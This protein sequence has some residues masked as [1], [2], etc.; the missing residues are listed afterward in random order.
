MTD[1]KYI[2]YKT[3]YINLKNQLG[4]VKYTGN[5]ETTDNVNYTWTEQNKDPIEYKYIPEDRNKILIVVDCGIKDF[6]SNL[7]GTAP[8][9]DTR[10]KPNN[11]YHNRGITIISV[12]EINDLNFDSYQ[13][14]SSN[15][16]YMDNIKMDNL[17]KIV[18][19]HK[20]NETALENPIFLNIPK[21][22]ITDDKNDRISEKINYIINLYNYVNSN[23]LVNKTKI[24]HFSKFHT[25]KKGVYKINKKIYIYN[26]NNLVSCIGDYAL[27]RY[28]IGIYRIYINKD[29]E[30]NILIFN[31]TEKLSIEYI[32]D[33][34]METSTL[35]NMQFVDY[36]ELEVIKPYVY[37]KRG[38]DTIY[39]HYFVYH[40]G[41]ICAVENIT[42][43]IFKLSDLCITAENLEPTDC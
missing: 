25:I 4:G 31:T 41:E 38:G 2:K 24:N 13:H 11:Y 43:F 36:P 10:Q 27:Y 8:Q 5:M 26:D 19:V 30:K 12:N 33:E 17:K 1:V 23:P 29:E 20:E 42:N 22:D 39:I 32:V 21:I 34:R 28:K 18:V 14:Q 6:I 15:I 40:K 9:T 35:Y 3:K 16:V 7:I 37:K